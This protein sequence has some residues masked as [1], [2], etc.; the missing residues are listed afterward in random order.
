MDQWDTDRGRA[1]MSSR[2]RA[3]SRTL[4]KANVGAWRGDIQENALDTLYLLTFGKAKTVAYRGNF[5]SK[6]HQAKHAYGVWRGDISYSR[7][8]DIM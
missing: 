3:V 2:P 1:D 4:G 5:A 6:H 8:D 7:I